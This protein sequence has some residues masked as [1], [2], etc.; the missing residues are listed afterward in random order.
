ME[1]DQLK[2]QLLNQVEA[3]F[4]VYA[5]S[6]ELEQMDEPNEVESES[7]VEAL[8]MED[9]KI[10]GVYEISGAWDSY[11]VLVDHIDTSYDLV[12][13]TGKILT[14][15][16]NCYLKRDLNVYSHSVITEI[17]AGSL[18][19]IDF[20]NNLI[21]GIENELIGSVVTAT[22][23][24]NPY[25]TGAEET[26]TVESISYSGAYPVLCEGDITQVVGNNFFIKGEKE[27]EEATV[28]T[29]LELDNGLVVKVG[30]ILVSD[31]LSAINQVTKILDNKSFERN[32]V[33]LKSGNV[34]RNGVYTYHAPDLRFATELE[35]LVF[36]EKT[37]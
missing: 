4:A 34:H 17:I 15:F 35:E 2:M 21:E 19:H 5:E 25:F 22:T 1:L 32:V 18:E 16:G 3:L 9:I 26:L 31:K 29:E 23:V 14:S 13:V 6:K 36:H 10:G 28:P 33:Y 12:T 20:M 27:P 7:D 30:A 8:T 24:G 37:N 11:T